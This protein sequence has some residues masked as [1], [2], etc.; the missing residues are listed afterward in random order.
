MLNPCAPVA[1]DVWQKKTSPL[2]PWLPDLSEELIPA[3]LCQGGEM[4]PGFLTP[5]QG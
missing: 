4:F 2:A 3:L 5:A 1:S